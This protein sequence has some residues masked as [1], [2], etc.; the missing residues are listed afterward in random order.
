MFS[1]MAIRSAQVTSI[2]VKEEFVD[3]TVLAGCRA[4]CW[5]NEFG[6][7]DRQN[8]AVL[9]SYDFKETRGLP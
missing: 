4:L 5:G 9:I 6:L 7:A 1:Q 3:L 8:I 2:K